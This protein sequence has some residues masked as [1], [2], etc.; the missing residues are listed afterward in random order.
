MNGLKILETA[1]KM[2]GEEK[3]N[4]LFVGSE[5][6]EYLLF[7]EADPPEDEKLIKELEF[8]GVY[9]VGKFECWGIDVDVLW[10]NRFKI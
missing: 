5:N 9:Y 6:Q 1:L 10:D 3:P 8:I 7:L 2:L 4:R